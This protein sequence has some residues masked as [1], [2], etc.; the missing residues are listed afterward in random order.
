[1]RAR[2]QRELTEISELTLGIMQ[3]LGV[4]LLPYLG[5]VQLQNQRPPRHDPF[6]PK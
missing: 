2:A 3:E 1:M 4:I 6:E 5:L